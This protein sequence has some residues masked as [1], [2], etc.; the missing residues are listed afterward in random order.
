[1]LSS[2]DTCGQQATFEAL[3]DVNPTN[4]QSFS[5]DINNQTF[6]QNPTT[7]TFQQAGS[8]P[9][10]FVLNLQNGCSYSSNGTVDIIPSITLHKLIFPN[11]ISTNS[12]AENHKWQIDSLYE[13]CASFN[14]QILNR[15]GQVVFET[16]T[17][18]KA[19]EG[20]NDQG[21]LLAEGIYFY[22]FTSGDEKRQ[23]FIHLI[24]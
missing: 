23:G 11:I 12:T 7:L 5:W 17:S 22:L 24:R 21:E 16:S 14:L 3:F 19:F 2:Q 9:Y 15:W 1:V 6:T 20:I 13:N 4:I 18:Q 8:Y 10:S